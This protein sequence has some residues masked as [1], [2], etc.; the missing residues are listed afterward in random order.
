MMFT[1]TQF[2]HEELNVRDV[3]WYGSQNN[4][5]PQLFLGVKQNVFLREVTNLIVLQKAR[6]TLR[7][8]RHTPH[9]TRHTPRAF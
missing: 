8:T 3:S 6:H 9:A 2:C 5:V 4:D 7:A 1:W